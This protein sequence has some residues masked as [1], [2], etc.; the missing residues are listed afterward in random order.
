M[1]SAGKRVVLI[2]EDEPF[3]AMAEKLVLERNGYAV[4]IA[5]NGER[6]I[7]LARTSPTIDLV[8]MDIDLGRG[9]DGT[10]AASVILRERDVPLAF[11]SSHTEAETVAKTE[12]ITSYGYIVKNSGETVLLAS[13]RM[14]F[15]LFEAKRLVGDT[16]THSINGL[17][18]HRMLYDTTGR[19]YDCLYVEV[20]DT[21]EGHT[22]HPRAEVL[23]RTIR[24]I[25]PNN[26]ADEVIA[27]YAEIL[28]GNTASRQE[29]YFPPS[30]D[31]FELNIW[32]IRNDD[33]TVVINNIT[34]RKRA[35]QAVARNEKLYR[36]LTE[37][38]VDGIKLL[39][40]EGKM[41][42]VN[43]A[44]ARMIGYRP[45]E[46]VGLSIADIDPDYP[47]ERFA[48]TW[49]DKPHDAPVQVR[50][51]HRHRDGHL[52]PVEVCA[53]P[54][55]LDG[56]GLVFGISRDV[57]AARQAEE[58]LRDRERE[59]HAL[60]ENAPDAVFI[61]EAANGTIVEVN[62]AAVALMRMPREQIIG[63][64]QSCL[65]PPQVSARSEATFRLH[66]E[67]GQRDG[68]TDPIE[69]EVLRADGS[70]VP[71]EVMAAPVRYRGI[72]CIMGT[73]RDLSERHAAAQRIDA[74]LNENQ[75]LAREILSR[76]GDR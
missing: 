66:R 24:D 25:Y 59:F 14:A 73:F 61:A 42:Q 52:V 38:S 49:A 41:L 53:I 27:M 50:T 15:R 10:E 12:S 18:I 22:G 1:D 6:A 60:F 7:E 3:I 67:Q 2:V 76:D 65:H 44:A 33:F 47:T 70:R 26:E 29:I 9:M 30:D 35:E 72:P 37:H 40:R 71:V 64:H 74:L 20:N 32:P 55:E 75:Q 13:I 28:A 8:L 48:N 45:E 54:F 39:N 58:A 43:P 36:I 63:L 46:L 21:F 31:W 69:A 11:L 5:P 34:E 56:E 16:F 51:Y 4:I 19:A 17:C 68:V 23:G 62:N 57:S